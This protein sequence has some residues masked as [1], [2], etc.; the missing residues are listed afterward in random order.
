MMMTTEECFSI[1]TAIKY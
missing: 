1:S